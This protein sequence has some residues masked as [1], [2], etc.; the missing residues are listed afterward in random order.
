[1][2]EKLIEAIRTRKVVEVTYESKNE[3]E[4]TRLFYPFTVGEASNDKDAVFGQQVVGGGGSHPARY[5]MENIKDIKILDTENS[6]RSA[7]RLHGRDLSLD[8]HRSNHRTAAVMAAKLDIFGVL[9]YLDANNLGVYEALR[10]DAE[11]LKEFER[12]VSWMLPQWM[13]G[14]TNDSDHAELIDNFNMICN[15]GWFELYGHPELQAKLLACCG[16]G[17][18]T[19]HKYYKPKK[20]PHLTKMMKFLRG[21]YIDIREGRSRN[22]GQSFYEGRPDALSGI[23]WISEK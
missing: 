22:V 23:P 14:A 16:T 19:R 6:S 1:M 11:M 9:S 5:N 15:D 21:K 4:K 17:H 7:G 13:T 3:G 2:K 10:E 18:R 8:N 20:V 12:N